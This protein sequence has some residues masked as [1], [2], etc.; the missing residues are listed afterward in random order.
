MRQV[1]G[2]L[3][4]LVVGALLVGGIWFALDQELTPW[5][6]P[7]GCVAVVDGATVRLSTEQGEN[8]ATIAAV[9]VGRGLPARA[10]T[11]A[12]ATV[13]QESRLLNLDYGDRDSLGLFQQRPSQGWGTKAQV[14]DPV[15][16]SNAFYDALVKVP[17]YRELEITVAAQTVQRSGFPDAYAQHEANARVLASALTGNS[18]KAF[19]CTVSAIPEAGSRELNELGLTRRA[20]D[21]RQDVLAVFGRIPTGGFE[22]RGVTSGHMSGSAHYSGR[23]VDLFFRPISAENKRRG[24]ALS[25][26]LVAHARRLGLGTII[27][28]DRIWHAGRRSGRGWSDYRVPTSSGGDILILEHRDHVHLDVP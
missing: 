1:R 27:F 7:D 6:D 24:W 12:L 21:A 13:Y 17:G 15:F 9:A 10:V 11:I 18:R 28:D 5:R 8:A 19:T 2:V 20:D 22:P 4:G 23:A 14:Q 3:V 25:H 16:A 26:Y